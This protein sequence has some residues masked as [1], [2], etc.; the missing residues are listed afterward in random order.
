[1]TTKTATKTEYIMLTF[2]AHDDELRRKFN[3][4]FRRS[5]KTRSKAAFAR[6]LIQESLDRRETK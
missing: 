6:A 3:R 2:G 5:K 4:F 1:M